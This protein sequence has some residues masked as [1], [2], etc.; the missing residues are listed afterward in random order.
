MMGTNMNGSAAIL[1][2]PTKDVTETAV[3]SAGER[4]IRLPQVLALV[5]LGKTTIYALM[6]DGEFPQPRKVRHLSLWV[7]SEV[8]AWIASVVKTAA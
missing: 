8:Q 1:M 2:M 6:K 5:G 3:S 4:L 7:E